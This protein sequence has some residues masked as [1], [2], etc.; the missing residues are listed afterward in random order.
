MADR[1]DRFQRFVRRGVKEIARG[2]PPRLGLRHVRLDDVVLHHRCARATASL[3]P[4]QCQERVHRATGNTKRDAT[5][6]DRIELVTGETIKGAVAPAVARIVAI[7][8]AL[9]RNEQ[10]VNGILVA[11]RAA[12]SQCV[13]DIVECGARFGIQEGLRFLGARHP[14]MRTKP[15]GVLTAAHEAPFSSDAV[16]AFHWCGLVWRNRGPPSDDPVRPPKNLLGNS[17]MEIWACA[18]ATV[19]LTYHPPSGSIRIGER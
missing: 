17:R 3:F 7:D 19:A 13:P 14:Q 1:L 6:P 18:R 12:Q 4:R 8:G 16:P 10:I 9:V 15:S 2:P 5:E 11:G